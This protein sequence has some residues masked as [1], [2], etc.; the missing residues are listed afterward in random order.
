MIEAI[1]IAL[2]V[3]AM[4]FVISMFVALIIKLTYMAIQR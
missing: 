1:Q 4:G 3:F 2:E